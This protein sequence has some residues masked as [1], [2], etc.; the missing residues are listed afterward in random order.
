M[1]VCVV[2]REERLGMM[3]SWTQ[4]VNLGFRD[5]FSLSN[6]DLLLSDR[7]FGKCNVL[8]IAT[9][10]TCLRPKCKAQIAIP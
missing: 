5:Y 1:F 7:A 3:D 9:F 6:V 10:H 8:N 4:K 2:E